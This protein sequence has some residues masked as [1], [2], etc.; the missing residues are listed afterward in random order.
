MARTAPAAVV[1]HIQVSTLGGF[2]LQIDGQ[3]LTDEINRSQKLWN[4]L[5]YLIVHRDR[6]VP[7]SELIELFW[8]E[9]NSANPNNALKTLLYRVRSLLLPLFPDGPDPILSQRG[10]YS[11]NP[12]IACTLDTDQFEALCRQAE[13]PGHTPE[14]RIAL[15]R[16]AC[17]LYQGN[18]LPKLSTQIWI[19]PLSA[20]YHALF[21][22]A[23]KAYAALLDETHAYE[24]MV[25]LCTR[26]SQLDPL[27]ESLHVLVVRA[28]LR[29]GKEA[30]ALSHYEKA[31]DLLYRNLGVRPSEELQELYREI[32][33]TEE[34]LETN[35]EVI[36]SH[37][38]ETAD[39][40]GAFVCE[41]GF[42]REAYRLEARRAAR[43]GACIHLALVTVAL[44]DG[45]TPPLGILNTTMDQLLEILTG[46]LRRGDVVSRYSAAQ[47]VV[48]LPAAN[49]ED[50]TMVMDRIVTAFYRQHRRNYL[51]LSYKIRELEI[52]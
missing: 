23:V 19:I 44:P 18:F 6:N 2:R 43:S 28:L 40:P 36:Q 15:Y 50:S 34:G 21:L 16:E 27:D 7:Q 4:V 1:K 14:E 25:R 31:T 35:L 45:G 41:Y 12:A 3:V 48:M 52:N 32:M 17:A 22:A 8:G 13:E 24:E 29:Q 10:S 47:Y 33:D 39:R 9:E 51:K 42:F 26:A 38:K 46:N 49:F 37:L 20:R 5:C 11:W 30:A